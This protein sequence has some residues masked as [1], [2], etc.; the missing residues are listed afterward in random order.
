LVVALSCSEFSLR[1]I[2]HVCKDGR[3]FSFLALL[4]N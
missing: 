3:S 1:S 4:G 2:T